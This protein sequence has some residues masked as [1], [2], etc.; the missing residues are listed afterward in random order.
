MLLLIDGG[1]WYRQFGNVIEKYKKSIY[2]VKPNLEEI[3]LTPDGNILITG[4]RDEENNRTEYW[5]IDENG[6]TL[7]NISSSV[8]GLNI[9]KNF[10]FYTTTDED[11]ITQ[12][13]CVTR[14]GNE[15]DDLLKLLDI[16]SIQK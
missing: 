6:K 5:L 14:T 9:S 8:E 1:N 7:T 15:R 11:M 3:S 4:I 12:V 2:D 10:I 13:Y 16:S